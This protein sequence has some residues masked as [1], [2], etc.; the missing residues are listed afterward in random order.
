VDGSFFRASLG[1]PYPISE[2][3]VAK[4]L[5]GLGGSAYDYWK[6]SGSISDYI[7]IPPYGNLFWFLFAG[8][9]FGTLPY[10]LLNIAPGNELYYYNKYVFNMMNRYEFLTDKYLGVSVEHIIGNGIFRLI[11]KLRWRQ[12]WTT[13]VLWGSLSDANYDLNFIQ[14]NSFQTLNG[15]TYMELGTGI[16]N[17]LHVLRVDFIWRVLP[18]TLDKK[19]DHSFGVFGSFRLSF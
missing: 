13:K 7:K 17:I 16:D 3:N 1:S 8:K 15:R 2:I 12:L 14:G 10:T 19:G 18:A 5:S 6:L 4:G 9:T 11:P